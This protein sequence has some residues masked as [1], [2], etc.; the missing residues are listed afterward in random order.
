MRATAAAIVWTRGARLA[1]VDQRGAATVEAG[2][3]NEKPVHGA[4]G[5]FKGQKCSGGG[6]S[7]HG[8]GVEVWEFTNQVLN[9]WARVMGF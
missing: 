9:L 1:A 8:L 5:G 3:G 7:L 4:E 2:G 6:L